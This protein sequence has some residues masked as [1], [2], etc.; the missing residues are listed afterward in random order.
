MIR[1]VNLIGYHYLRDILIRFNRPF[2]MWVY[3]KVI[4]RQGCSN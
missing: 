4:G 1:F 3:V 2:N